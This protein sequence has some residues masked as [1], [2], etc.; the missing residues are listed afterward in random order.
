M[1]LRI[2]SLYLFLVFA[3]GFLL[4]MQN[5]IVNEIMYQ[6]GDVV[7]IEF[8]Q[9]WSDARVLKQS[10]QPIWTSN[11]W[12]L[13]TLSVLSLSCL[14]AI[15][16]PRNPRKQFVLCSVS[17][18]LTCILS[19]SLLLQFRLRLSEIGQG[20]M[21]SVET[22]HLLWFGLFFAFQISVLRLLWGDLKMNR[23]SELVD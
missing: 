4:F 15:F 22:P 23:S 9:F 7:H 14:L 11:Y 3:L 8:V 12:H 19:G 2:Q 21:E 5:P 1:I 16:F 10:A 13:S 18:L 20:I 6:D 17:L